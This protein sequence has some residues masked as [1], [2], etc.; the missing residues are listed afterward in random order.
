MIANRP[1]TVTF[2]EGGGLEMAQFTPLNG[3]G[4]DVSKIFSNMGG[5]GGGAMGGSVSIELL[6]SPDLEARVVQNSL[7]KTAEIITGFREAN[8]VE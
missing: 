5:S 4:K 6:L 3:R 8:N 7:N 1:T 2:G